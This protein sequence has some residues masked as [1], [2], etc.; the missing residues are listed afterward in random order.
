[1]ISSGRYPLGEL[2]PLVPGD[3]VPAGVKQEDRVVLDLPDDVLV[4]RVGVALRLHPRILHDLPGGRGA[5][6]RT[7]GERDNG[8]STQ[9]NRKCG[10]GARPPALYHGR[11]IP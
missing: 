9:V 4:Q 11:A 3:D 1:M 7:T 8:Q 2:R 10:P 5:T 6:L